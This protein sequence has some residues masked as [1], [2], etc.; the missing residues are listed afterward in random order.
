MSKSRMGEKERVQLFKGTVIKIQNGGN[1]CSFTVRKTSNGVGVEKTFL[2]ASPSID[3]IERLRKGKVRRARLFYLRQLVGKAA[4][5]KSDIKTME[6]G[7]TKK[8][9]LLSSPVLGPHLSEEEKNTSDQAPKTAEGGIPSESSPSSSE[10][11]KT[12]KL[13]PLVSTKSRTSN[14][15]PAQE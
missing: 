15:S 12:E 1:H 11:Q 13:S 6:E 5:I 8:S 4:H 7:R 2:L 3:K 9:K 14:T 10:N